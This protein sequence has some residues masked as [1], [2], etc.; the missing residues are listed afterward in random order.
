MLAATKPHIFDYTSGRF[1][2][3]SVAETRP[4]FFFF[5]Q[6]VRT[7]SDCVSCNKH[8]FQMRHPDILPA[9]SLPEKTDIFDEMSGKHHVTISEPW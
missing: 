5:L 9:V 4:G 6:D 3:L 7:L 2:A 1:T 8:I